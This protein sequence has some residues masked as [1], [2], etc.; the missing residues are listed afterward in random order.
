MSDEKK[1]ENA[2]LKLLAEVTE[3]NRKLA[4]LFE[5]KEADASPDAMQR[6]MKE[7]RNVP[8]QPTPT[9]KDVVSPLTGATFDAVLRSETDTTVLR[10]E[11]VR[12]PK[13]AAVKQK[14]GGLVPDGDD[15]PIYNGSQQVQAAI[16]SEG[17]DESVRFAAD[18]GLYTREYKNWRFSSLIQPDRLHYI[19][20]PL[21]GY[22]APTRAA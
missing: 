14:F 3:T 1:N 2:L 22:R 18:E 17:L 10:I 9:I 15:L 6:R 21:P 7:A 19:G 4:D 11:N 5:R 20:K 12:M 16:N 13:G 8:G